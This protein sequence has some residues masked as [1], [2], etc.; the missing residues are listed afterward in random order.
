MSHVTMFVFVS[1]P[2]S[3]S[4]IGYYCQYMTQVLIYIYICIRTSVHINTINGLQIIEHTFVIS[5][6]KKN[7]IVHR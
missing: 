1:F 7:Y 5:T 4:V 6:V 2:I 3:L